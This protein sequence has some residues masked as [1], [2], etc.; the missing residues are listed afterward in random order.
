MIEVEELIKKLEEFWEDWPVAVSYNGELL[1][2][3]IEE[4]EGYILISPGERAVASRRFGPGRDDK[5]DVH[6]EHCCYFC[7]CKYGDSN[8]TVRKGKLKQ[9][10]EHLNTSVCYDMKPGYDNW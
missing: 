4:A 7:T 1:E 5:K 6:T 2:P 3:K 9:S 10:H 8:C